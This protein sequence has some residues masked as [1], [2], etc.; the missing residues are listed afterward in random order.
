MMKAGTWERFLAG[1]AAEA[2]KPSEK[3]PAARAVRKKAQRSV[4][5][6]EDPENCSNQHS[7]AVGKAL[8]AGHRARVQEAK[9]MA[10]FAAGKVDSAGQKLEKRTAREQGAFP[11]GHD[12]NAEARAMLMKKVPRSTSMPAPVHVPASSIFARMKI[13]LPTAPVQIPRGKTLPKP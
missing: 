9:E 13:T 8:K 5:A 3:L 1:G 10:D 11:R 12:E 4:F 6:V 2:P 7:D